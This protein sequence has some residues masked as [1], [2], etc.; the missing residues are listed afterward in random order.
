MSRLPTPSTSG[1]PRS[2]RISGPRFGY[3]PLIDRAAFTTA[4]TPLSASP[5]A[6]TRSR[7]SWS[8]NATSPAW[9]RRR[10]FLVRRSTRAA[11]P[12]SRAPRLASLSATDPQL[13]LP[14]GVIGTNIAVHA[15]SGAPGT[16]STRR[17][18]RLDQL[19]RVGQ[20][21]PRRPAGQHPCQLLHPLLP[22][23]HPDARRATLLRH[24]EVPVGPG[25][26]L[27]QVRHHEDLS[28]PGHL[29]QPLGHRGGG[30]P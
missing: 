16:R 19:P 2:T 1:T 5:S 4:E 23:E 18:P 17:R 26:D 12:P 6:L 10:R 8:M 14:W 24:Q 3:R 22:L 29:G 21:R 30:A 7:S 13:G 9:T 20:R 28:P 25:R 11:R 15:G 27:G